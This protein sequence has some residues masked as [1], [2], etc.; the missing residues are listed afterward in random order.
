MRWTTLF[1]A[2]CSLAAA[3]AAVG[4]IPPAAVAPAPSKAAVSSRAADPAA[5]PAAAPAS[6]GCLSCHPSAAPML[7]TAMT[8]RAGERA[9]CR[10]AFAGDGE[11]FFAQSCTGCHVSGCAD[12]HGGA[13]H[14][15]ASRRP[16]TEA[17]LRCHR[18]YF[19][20]GEYLGRAP[21]ED[22]ARYQR[23]PE[24]HGERSLKM[25]PDVHAERGMT[26]ADCHTMRAMS[27]GRKAARTCAECHPSPSR[28]VPEHAIAAHLERMECA[29]CHSAWAAQEYG[30]FLV[31]GAPDDAQE[32]FDAALPAWGDFRKSAVLKRQDPPPLGLDARGRVAPIRPQ[33]V[34]FATDASRGIE[35]RLL[36]AE[37]RAFFPH[38][39]RRGTVTC[40]GCHENPRRYLLEADEDRHYLLEKDGLPL[41]SFWSQ[42]GQ[43]VV[44]GSFLSREAHE[45][46]NRKTPD[47]VR[48]HLKQWKNLLDRADGRSAR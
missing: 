1:T 36:A 23:G 9:F 3:S 17:C 21:R 5:T 4:V 37:W 8:T 12:C 19:V 48:Q 41:R 42:D 22:H 26:C 35:N 16:S 11:R 43:T 10:R 28:D 38:T 18:G 13:P 25:L 2:A 31:R 14:A 29:A 27:T 33:F 40:G 44:N 46:M 7:A 6:A 24:A 45:R 34:L 15:A 30:T 47:Y 39:V 32:V 20:G